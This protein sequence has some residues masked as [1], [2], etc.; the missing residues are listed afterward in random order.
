MH[1]HHLLKTTSQWQEVSSV[2]N[3]GALR[4]SLPAKK[5]DW[6]DV[7]R[8]QRERDGLTQLG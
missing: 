4:G 5:G 7:W 2:S 3:H 8:H 1:T 6:E